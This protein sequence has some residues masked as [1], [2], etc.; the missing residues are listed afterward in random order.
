MKGK[1]KI[2]QNY[3]KNSDRGK[4]NMRNTVVVQLAA[5]N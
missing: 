5:R 2:I 4:K 1:K 3:D